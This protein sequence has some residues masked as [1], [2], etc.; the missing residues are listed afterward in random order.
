[1]NQWDKLSTYFNTHGDNSDIKSGAADNILIAW[2]SLLKGIECIQHNGATLHALDYGCGGGG[3]SVIGC[4]ASSAMISMAQKNWSHIKFYQ[5]DFWKI[6][7]LPGSPFDLIT[8]IM[9]IQ[10]IDNMHQFF[11]NINRV[12]NPGGLLAFAVFNPDYVAKNHG[13]GK[14]FEGF[15]TPDRPTYGFLC[16]TK[17]TRIPVFIRTIEEY[18]QQIISLGYKKIYADKPEFTAQYLTQF[19]TN[20]DTGSPEFLV[21]VYQKNFKDE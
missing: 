11:A 4:D 5:C 1:M 19:K 12:L 21:L 15:E 7:K 6:D 13:R 16:L 14:S 18:D 10:F 2:P 3:Y 8:S 17:G 9:V 20:G